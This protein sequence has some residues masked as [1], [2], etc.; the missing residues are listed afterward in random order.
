MVSFK[1]SFVF[2]LFYLDS[3]GVVQ[4]IFC[5]LF[6]LSWWLWCRSMDL[7]FFACFILIVMVSFK[8]AF[9]VCLFYLDGYGVVQ[10]I[11]LFVLPWWL[12]CRSM[13][14]L[15]FACFIDSYG[16]VQG[17]F[18]FLLVLPWWLWCRSRDLLF[19][20]CFILMV[21]VSFKGSFV[22]VCFILMVM[23]SFKGSFVFCL[24]YLDGYGVVQGIFLLVLPWWLWCRARDL[25]FFVCFIL[26]VMVS[27]KGSFVFCLFYL[28]SYGVVQGIFC[29]LFV[30][31]WW[32]WC[33]SRDLLLFACFTFMVMVSFKGSFVFCLFYLDGYGVVQGIFCCLFY[34]DG[35]GV[36]HGIFCCLIVLP[37]WLW[38]RSRDLLLFACFTFIVM[39]SFKRSFVF[40]LFY[41]DSY[42]VVQ[43]IFCCL[44]VLPW[45][46]WCRSRDLLLFVCFIL[47]VMV[48][49]KGSFV[50]CCF[51]LM[52][53]VSF[54]GSFVVCLFYL[55]GYGVVQGIF[56][57]CLFYLYGYGVVQGSF[58]LVLS[59]WLWCRSRDLLLFA[60]F[61]FMVMVSF[62]G[63]FVV[64]LFYLYSYGVVQGIFCFC[65]FYLDGYGVVQGIFCCLLVLSLWLWCRS[66]DLLLF[67]CFI[68]IVMVSFKGSFVVCLFY[69]YSYGVVQG[70]FLFF[71]C[72]IFIV[73]VSFKGS[74]VVCL[75]YLYGYGVVQGIFCCLLVLS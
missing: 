65:L 74:F 12:W 36:V 34:L 68:F 53:M 24:F 30:L 73:M 20:A 75:F 1:G 10:G 38:C 33:R 14:L 28:Y 18:C 32:L 58:L 62:K 3:Y 42:G 61:T 56:C 29:C 43:G 26:I 9:V 25:S 2:C 6:V 21:M 66:R 22:F 13:D 4:G 52:V 35:Y 46:L 50:V 48:S 51:I 31:S 71:A 72:F 19:F 11:F 57:F 60:C 41:L 67:V 5:F 55:Y 37:L 69:L 47:M 23:V 40:C 45:W 17:I 7:L 70:I 44:L 59:W 15:F 8:G 39:V 27:F 49:F 54:K 64:C 16:V 63:S